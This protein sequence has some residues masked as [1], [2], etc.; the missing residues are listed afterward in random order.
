MG[1]ARAECS[2]RGDFFI[3]VHAMAKDQLAVRQ[4]NTEGRVASNRRPRLEHNIWLYALV[5]LL[6]ENPSLP[7]HYTQWAVHDIATGPFLAS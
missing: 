2:R 6:T 7:L 3:L 1:Y 5:L 4:K